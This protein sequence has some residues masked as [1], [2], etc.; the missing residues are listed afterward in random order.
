MQQKRNIRK[1]GFPH[2]LVA[3][4]LQM[5]QSLKQQ[6]QQAA[7]YLKLIAPHHVQQMLNLMGNGFHFIEAHGGG[8]AFN[9]VGCTKNRLNDVRGGIMLQME[10]VLLHPLQLVYHFPD[11]CLTVS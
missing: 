6:I 5:V 8:R 3:Q 11:E 9:G 1:G 4:Q 7:P 10:Q 2:I